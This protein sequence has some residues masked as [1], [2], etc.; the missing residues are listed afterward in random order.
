MM[1]IN[2]KTI[3]LP[4][5][6]GGWGLLLEPVIVALVLCPHGSA[7]LLAVS[8]I[9]AFLM[10]YP[11]KIAT[12]D[13]L[14]H[15]RTPRTML[16]YQFSALYGFIALVGILY[17]FINSKSLF[18]IPL[19]ISLPLFFYQ[20][21]AALNKE[22]RNLF[23]EISGAVAL[24]SVAPAILIS[25]ERSLIDAFLIWYLFMVRGFFSIVY[26][27]NRLR[28]AR[29]QAYS[30]QQVAIVHS[31]GLVSIL[32]LVFIKLIP[33]PVLAGYGI[34]SAHAYWGMKSH[35]SLLKPKDIGWQEMLFGVINCI[36][37]IL[38]YY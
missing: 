18:W 17:V 31:L 29:K 28:A 26:V 9:C 6:H 23:P 16:A 35:D 24:A 11:L 3:A 32:I 14:K 22:H 1:G 33:Y 12:E 38:A 30:G 36:F 21:S 19:L 37:I 7:F 34:L 15:Q 13:T 27:R 20:F 25:G 2:I 5:E 8:F 10:Y 4:K